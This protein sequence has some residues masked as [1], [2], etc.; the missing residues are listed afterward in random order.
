MC[1]PPE[2]WASSWQRVPVTDSS[3][4]M[5]RL[6]LTDYEDPQRA[7]ELASEGCP[8]AYTQIARTA[9]E[10]MSSLT[11]GGMAYMAFVSRM[12]GLHEGAVRE[13]AANNPHAALPLIRAWAEVIT[14]GLYVL[15]HPE[16]VE[17]LLHGPGD[18]RPGK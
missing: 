4:D 8:Q 14:I 17:F 18:G 7:I 15:R 13:I 10:A 16:Y 6:D 1:D 5:I 12:R 11:T 2:T 3:D 9:L